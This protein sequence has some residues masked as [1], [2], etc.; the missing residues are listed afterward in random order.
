MGQDCARSRRRGYRTV[1]AASRGQSRAYRTA[2]L[3]DEDGRVTYVEGVGEGLDNG[4]EDTGVVFPPDSA[5]EL[6]Q[7]E[8]RVEA[9]KGLDRSL[10]N[11]GSASALSEG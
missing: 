7:A 8:R 6:F 1:V 3:G 5:C 2:T 4:R 11:R 9:R 10:P